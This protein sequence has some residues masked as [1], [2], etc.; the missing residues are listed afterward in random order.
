VPDDLLWTCEQLPNRLGRPRLPSALRCLVVVV[1]ASSFVVSASGPPLDPAR[2]LRVNVTS[3]G[4]MA[5]ANDTYNSPLVPAFTFTVTNVGDQRTSALQVNAL[6]YRSG[7]K[8][9]GLGTTF[10]PAVGWRGLTPGATSHALVLRAQGWADRA[11]MTPRGAER[12]AEPAEARVKLFVQ[13]EGRWT[14]LGDF[15]IRAHL[16]QP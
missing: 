12:H 3:T 2:C 8:P 14:L 16:M 9:D 13:H 11:P 6:F 7:P 1:A 5:V 15:P 10:S 4:W